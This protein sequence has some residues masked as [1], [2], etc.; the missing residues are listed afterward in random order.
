[1]DLIFHSAVGGMQMGLV[2]FFDIC[3]SIKLRCDVELFWIK[4]PS[5]ELIFQLAEFFVAVHFR[6]AKAQ[7]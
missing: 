4:K 5:F 6:K 1:M 2:R 7:N 3:Y